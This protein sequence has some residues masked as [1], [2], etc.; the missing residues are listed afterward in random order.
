MAPTVL[1]IED[2]YVMLKI[3]QT[4]LE[5]SGFKVLTSNNSRLGMAKAKEKQPNIIL[6]DSVLP[7]LDGF[8]VCKRLKSDPKTS[9]I[10]VIIMSN[11]DNADDHR[12]AINIGASAYLIKYHT[13][14]ER[15]IDMIT[16]YTSSEKDEEPPPRMP[17]GKL[18][19]MEQ[20]KGDL[21]AK[22]GL[23]SPQHLKEALKKVG[24]TGITLP[25][26]LMSIEAVTGTLK[27][28]VLEFFY[29]ADYVDLSQYLLDKDAVN[30]V[31]A[32]FARHFSVI[33]MRFDE[34]K[35]I[36]AMSD[37]MDV[38]IEEDLRTRLK[39]PIKMVY[40]P[41][42]D[43]QKA[44][45]IY[46][47]SSLPM[48][49]VMAEIERDRAAG[50][51]DDEEDIMVGTTPVSKL[52]D[53][54]M[55]QAIAMKSSDIHFEPRAEGM[56][57][58]FRIDG[59]LHDIQ[60]IPKEAIAPVVSRIKIISNLD[61]TERRRPQDGRIEMKIA[62]KKIDF[63]VSTTPVALGEKIVLRIL[64]KSVALYGIS[65]LGLRSI[66]EKKF[67]R[68]LRQPDGMILVTGPTGSGKTTS[69]YAALNYLKSS[70]T[71]IISLE[72]PVEFTIDGINQIP[73]NPKVD[74]T[75]ATALRSVLRQDPDIIMIGEI[76]D[77]ETAE[78]GIQA[79]L[80]GHLV[81]GTLHTR[82]APGAISRLVDM[83]VPP[84]LLASTLIGVIAQRLVRKVC[85]NCAEIYKLSS[86]ADISDDLRAE[87]TGID[88]S[89]GTG[90][91]FC[92]QM[93]YHGRIGV[94][95]FM[96]ISN[97]IKK[98][99]VSGADTLELTEV[100]RSEGMLTLREDATRLVKEGITTWEE[101]VTVI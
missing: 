14:P 51:L 15:L 7:D 31:T 55:T 25:Q 97:R 42:A 99:I 40:A 27:D 3:W 11:F 45:A 96:E 66:E 33:P 79:A 8:D 87:L 85:D 98:L 57:V 84:Y 35:L 86:D 4:E 18:M 90:C 93:G 58:R 62:E 50:K 76:R 21:L 24:L 44:I 49:E 2:N 5:R 16:Y 80:T 32:D 13:M 89:R 39:R 19:D 53:T 70:E 26:A 46:Y 64:D 17:S 29:A 20:R 37:P 41:E 63:R 95:E 81:L 71:N 48:E 82:N 72:D 78:L 43:I 22:A 6:V 59:V 56:M 38:E 101:M 30:L 94:F 23:I 88:L 67:L 74:L 28:Q 60:V 77:Q 83:G 52:I 92:R 68:M 69:L 12:N 47:G 1:I 100:A 54:V 9:E 34:E 65:E 73:I 36:V 61:I 75:F 10:P 91:D